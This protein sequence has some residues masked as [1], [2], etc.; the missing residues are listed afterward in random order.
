GAAEVLVSR[1]RTTIRM[2]IAG[3]AAMISCNWVAG[4]KAMP[5]RMTTMATETTQA[6]LDSWRVGPAAA[7]PSRMSG[8]GRNLRYDSAIPVHVMISAVPVEASTALN[9]TAG[10][11]WLSRVIA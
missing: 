2:I 9:T 8:F 5:T 11:T 4:T 1:N 10:A 6:A 3:S 7:G